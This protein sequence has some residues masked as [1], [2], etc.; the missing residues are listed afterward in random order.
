MGKTRKV[1]AVPITLAF[2]Y[3]LRADPNCWM[4]SLGKSTTYHGSIEAALESFFREAVRTE[5]A[6]RQVGDLKA[7][8]DLCR[9]VRET[10]RMLARR[11]LGGDSDGMVT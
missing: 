10:G 3:T 9:E 2:G 5:T 11:V 6:R 7:L 8:A 1:T 4:L